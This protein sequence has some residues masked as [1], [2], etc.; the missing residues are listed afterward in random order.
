M[1]SALP[2]HLGDAPIAYTDLYAT[3]AFIRTH[4]GQ[5][6]QHRMMLHT[7][8]VLG[9]MTGLPL[10]GVDELAA[11][12][13]WL[14]WDNSG[15]LDLDHPE[16]RAAI[17]R[18]I[19]AQRRDLSTVQIQADRRVTGWMPAAHKAAR[20]IARQVGNQVVLDGGTLHRLA[21][22][23][24]RVVLLAKDGADAR[25]AAIDNPTGL[26]GALVVYTGGNGRSLD[27]LQGER[28]DVAVCAPRATEGA[29]FQAV[30]DRVLA[31]LPAAF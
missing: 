6:G 4:P 22:A 28:F 31:C 18:D 24:P 19:R 2:P 7:E 5:L 23:A 25:A 27:R 21:P 17:E 3:Q 9:A 15:R 29:W 1:T 12:A 11:V 30:M 13:A 8:A 16:L 20:A 26:H 14:C 10:V